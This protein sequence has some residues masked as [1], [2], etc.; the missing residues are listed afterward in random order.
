MNTRL[1]LSLLL[2]SLCLTFLWLS[3]VEYEPE[4]PNIP[5]VILSYL[6]IP[7]KFSTLWYELL[8]DGLFGSAFLIK[9]LLLLEVVP[10]YWW[11]QR[12]YEVPKILDCSK[13]YVTL[14]AVWN[15]L[16]ACINGIAGIENWYWNPVTQTPGTFDLACHFIAGTLIVGWLLTLK[17]PKPI[18]LAVGYIIAVGWEIYESMHP[19]QYWNVYGNSLADVAAFLLGAIV[20]CWLRRGGDL[21]SSV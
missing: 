1:F 3:V 10:L 15:L 5:L 12:R 18:V 21:P 11:L 2:L 17:V 8:F 16:G 9:G 6:F 14:M 19:E 4:Q 7:Q 20:L 13:K